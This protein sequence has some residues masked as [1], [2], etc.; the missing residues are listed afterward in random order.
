MVE[1]R[2]KNDLNQFIDALT[3]DPAQI[4]AGQS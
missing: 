3:Y 1:W 4:K 2:S